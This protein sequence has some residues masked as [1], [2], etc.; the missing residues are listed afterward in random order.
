M[1][2]VL[3]LEEIVAARKYKLGFSGAS[4]TPDIMV[5]NIQVCAL[6]FI[7]AG[8]HF[9]IPADGSRSCDH[10]QISGDFNKGIHSNHVHSLR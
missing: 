2:F 6:L 5:G 9:N 8:I 10:V 7:S 4:L 1:T 3:L